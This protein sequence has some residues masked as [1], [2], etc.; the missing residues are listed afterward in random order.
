MVTPEDVDNRVAE[1]VGACRRHGVKA[2]HQRTEI[3]RELSGTAEHSDVETI[4]S[5]V[6]RRIPAISLDTVYRTLRMLE[7]KGVI[8]RVGSMQERVRFDANTDRHHHFIC[9]ECGMIGDFYSEARTRF[10]IPPEVAEI[11]SVDGVYV[12][13]RGR[14]RKC[15]ARAKK[16]G[17][18]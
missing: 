8:A 13:V 4:H 15:Q 11:G 14:C 12:E 1:F 2:T 16:Q 6:L 18:R 10:P 3:V 7:D 17:V 5:R 9:C